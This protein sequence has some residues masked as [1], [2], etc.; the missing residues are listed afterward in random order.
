MS[1]NDWPTGETIEQAPT[2]EKVQAAA[3]SPEERKTP[4]APRQSLDDDDLL[5]SFKAQ[6]EEMSKWGTN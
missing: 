2:P 5:S 3:P 4:D 1:R 6:I